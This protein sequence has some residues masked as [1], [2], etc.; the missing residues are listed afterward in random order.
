MKDSNFNYP[1]INKHNLD[2]NLKHKG[3]KKTNKGEAT[4]T[5][6]NIFINFIYL[7]II[8]DTFITAAFEVSKK[9]IKRQKLEKSKLLC[10]T[11]KR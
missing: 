7:Y 10:R 3:I 9:N 2:E 11:N 1:K 4:Q 8:M 5:K 6:N